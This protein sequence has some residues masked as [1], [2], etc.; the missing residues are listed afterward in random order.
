[1]GLW[2]LGYDSGQAGY[3][4]ALALTFV[5]PQITSLT[6]T[7]DPTHTLRVH[8]ELSTH[9][10][11]RVLGIRLSADGVHWGARWAPGMTP[12]WTLPDGPDG[13]TV[14]YVLPQLYGGSSGVGIPV[15][16]V[17]DRHAPEFGWLHLT[18]SAAAGKWVLTFGATD[19]TGVARYEV[20]YRVNGGAW[21]TLYRDP[22]G[23]TIRFGLPHTT[24]LYIQVRALD[25][26]G[27]WSSWRTISVG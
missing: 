23:T 25:R 19:L 15:P 16:V 7:P 27:L 9:G 2:A 17:L 8:L 22:G 4:E 6:V 1:M 11:P 12:S 14:V 5:Y 10:S 21:H 13:P 26:A 20:R 3:W 24:R 18:W